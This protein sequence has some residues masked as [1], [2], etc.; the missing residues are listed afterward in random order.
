VDRNLSNKGKD[1]GGISDYMWIASIGIH[2]VISSLVGLFAGIYI[3]KW[4]HTKPVFMFVLFIIGL[5]AGF[6]QL[7]KEIKK[8]DQDSK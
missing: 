5:A 3:D 6:R 4:L 2:L 8:I 1:T 7:F